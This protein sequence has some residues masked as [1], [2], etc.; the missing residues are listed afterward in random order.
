MDY[1]RVR[2]DTTCPICY[3]AKDRG[4]IACW[5]CFRNSG[6]KDGATAPD[7]MIYRRETALMIR[8]G[9]AKRTY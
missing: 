3:R 8:E 5:P 4:L 6:L 9:E 1:P 7:R 2:A